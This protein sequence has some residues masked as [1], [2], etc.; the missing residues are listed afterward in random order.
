[1]KNRTGKSVEAKLNGVERVLMALKQQCHQCAQ[2]YE[3]KNVKY[4]RNGLE[5]KSRKPVL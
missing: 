5:K 2:K 1:M 3:D 4:G